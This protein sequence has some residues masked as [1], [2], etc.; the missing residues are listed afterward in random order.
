MQHLELAVILGL[1][2]LLP[3]L[4]SQ[5]PV[6]NTETYVL[7]TEV[8]MI[9]VHAT[10]QDRQGAF[11]SGLT[12]DFFTITEGGVRQEFGTFI[13]DDVPL[14]VGLVIDNSGR[15]VQRWEEVITGALTF[16]CDS[17]PEHEMFV[18]HLN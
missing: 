3:P 11:I 16:V 1:T 10:V 17:R 14:A 2:S 12:K 7:R 13:S 9:V 18:V 15:M 8:N 4:L 5:Q 6:G